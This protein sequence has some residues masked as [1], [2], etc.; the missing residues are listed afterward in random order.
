MFLDLYEW[1][2]YVYVIFV[3]SYM[4][5]LKLFLLNEILYI[6]VINTLIDNTHS[7]KNYVIIRILLQIYNVY[8]FISVVEK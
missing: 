7:H 4:S 2:Q 3:L 1:N 5:G 6:Y 8:V